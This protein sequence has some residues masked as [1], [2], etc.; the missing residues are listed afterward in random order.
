M[1]VDDE[2]THH[3]ALVNAS[4]NAEPGY[5]SPF[6][7]LV[8][9]AAGLVLCVVTTRHAGA[10]ALMV[11]H[12]VLLRRPLEILLSIVDGVNQEL[13]HLEPLIALFNMSTA[14][15]LRILPGIVFNQ[16]TFSYGSNNILNELS[17]TVPNSKTVAIVRAFSTGKSTI[18]N[19]LS[20]DRS[21]NSGAIQIDGK[22]L[23]DINGNCI[24]YASQKPNFLHRSILANLQY[25]QP[26]KDE[27]VVQEICH[28]VGIHDWILQSSEGYHTQ[29]KPHLFSG[30]EL[31]MLNTARALI[32]K[33]A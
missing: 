29:Y 20:R 19:L 8:F 21:P 2:I 15:Q 28:A 33:S 10:M 16:V 30:G 9:F 3:G 5:S 22:D 25:G 31:Q 17:F 27:M 13:A 32:R 6:E 12:L 23:S 1:V 18:C 14:D 11:A 4:L 7:T 24:T 26:E